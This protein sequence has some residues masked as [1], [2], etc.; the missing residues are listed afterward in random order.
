MS[1]INKGDKHGR[2]TAVKFHHRNKWSNQYWI[3]KC[4][5]GE[6]RV[7]FIGSVKNNITKSCGCLNKE[8]LFKHGMCGTETYNSWV[9]MKERCL[10]KNRKSYKDY[11]GRGITVCPEWME[12]KNFY[13]DMG[14]RPEGKTLDRIDNNKGYYKE[15]CRWATI[16]EQNNNK[17]IIN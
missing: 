3:F 17:R 9:A 16:K 15:N 5:C 14:N 7:L 13:K 11:G 4:D 6:E 1:I 8:N 2:L 10:N 12:F